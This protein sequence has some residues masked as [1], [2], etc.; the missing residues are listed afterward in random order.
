MMGLLLVGEGRH[1]IGDWY[2][3]RPTPGARS[4]GVV[5]VLL[6]KVRPDGWEIEEALL[7]KS[8]R[9]Y[10]PG[11]HRGAETRTVLGIVQRA[12]ERDL[13]AV[14]FSRDRDSEKPEG[15]R[16]ESEVE[17]GIAEART[18]FPQGPPIAG[19]VAEAPGAVRP[20]PQF[21]HT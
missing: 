15:R 10:R 16:R 3:G 9:K 12:A 8:V 19:G 7:W 6:R 17:R 11:G 4:P 13:A 1:E 5:E 20:P 21:V 2:D 18:V 14:V